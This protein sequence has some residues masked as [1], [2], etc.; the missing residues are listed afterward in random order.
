MILKDIQ[1]TFQAV[2]VAVEQAKEYFQGLE[3]PKLS[4]KKTFI[5]FALRE[6]LNNAVKHGNLLDNHKKIIYRIGCDGKEIQLDIWDEGLGFTLPDR[7]WDDSANR[8]LHM[9]SRGLFII[10]KMSFQ[11]SATEGHIIATLEI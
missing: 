4:S 9:V 1:S 5:V 3:C 2:D 10:Q 6:L 7:I 11:L 8:V